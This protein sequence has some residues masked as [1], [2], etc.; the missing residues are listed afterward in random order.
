MWLLLSEFKPT[1]YTNAPE[2]MLNCYKRQS[3]HEAA[4][5]KG[6]EVSPEPLPHLVEAQEV[7]NGGGGV[8]EHPVSHHG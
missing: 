5:I 3:S 2:W 4:L 8:E 7:L 1:S 6:K